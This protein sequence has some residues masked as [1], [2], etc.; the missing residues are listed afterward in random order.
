M[1][2]YTVSKRMEI[3]AAHNL[4]LPYESKCTNLHG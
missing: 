2:K 4:D 3:A 1:E